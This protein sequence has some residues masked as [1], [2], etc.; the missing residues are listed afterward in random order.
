MSLFI[1]LYVVYAYTTSMLRLSL[2][3]LFVRLDMHL[4][5]LVAGVITKQ[6]VTEA[7]KKGIKAEQVRADESA[8]FRCEPYSFHYLEIRLG[9]GSTPKIQSIRVYWGNSSPLTAKCGRGYVWH[10]SPR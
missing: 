6:S 10:P 9:Y 1:L 4:P 5:N 2:L 3:K 7:F 8:A